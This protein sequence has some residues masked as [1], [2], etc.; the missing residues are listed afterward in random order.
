MGVGSVG[1]VISTLMGF[2]RKNLS[3]NILALLL[4]SLTSQ[5]LVVLRGGNA[6]VCLP[7]LSLANAQMLLVSTAWL[8][9]SW[10][11]SCLV[12][13]MVCC[14]VLCAA[15]CSG[16]VAAVLATVCAFVHASFHQLAPFGLGAHWGSR[17][18]QLADSMAWLRSAIAV[19]RSSVSALDWISAVK[20]L[21]QASWRSA[22][23][24]Y[25]LGA[26]GGMMAMLVIG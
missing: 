1:C 2:A 23:S 20:A 26:R 17:V 4:G 16:L 18:S 10:A 6:L 19:C 11:Q 7:F 22:S 8:S 9:L 21:V 13:A 15:F 3:W 24:L 5:L 25:P 14:R 12:V